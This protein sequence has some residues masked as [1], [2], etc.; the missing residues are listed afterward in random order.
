MGSQIIVSGNQLESLPRAMFNKHHL[1]YPKRAWQKSG[2]NA[3]YL[4][5]EFIVHLPINIH[6]ML[7]REIDY[8]LGDECSCYLPTR[9]TL[10]NLAGMYEMHQYELSMLGAIDKLE[11]LD[12]RLDCCFLNSWLHNLI[13]YELDFL[14]RHEEEIF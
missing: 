9:S 12:S 7:H 11:W 13:R 2:A 10:A 5:G 6:Q 3:L 8:R 14:I 1:L 4:R